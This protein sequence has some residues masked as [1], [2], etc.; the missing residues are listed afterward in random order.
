[1]LRLFRWDKDIRLRIRGTLNLEKNQGRRI[2]LNLLC[3]NSINE[4][5]EEIY[6][7]IVEYLKS[8]DIRMEEIYY[9]K[10]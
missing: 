7:H 9:G 8:K 3:N 4:E 5:A 1:M 6:N 10:H 2:Q